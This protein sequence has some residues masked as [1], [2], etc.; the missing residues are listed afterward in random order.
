MRAAR[1]VGSS[2]PFYGRALPL[3]RP[4]SVSR[5]DAARTPKY[6]T[7]L[8]PCGPAPTRTGAGRSTSRPQWHTQGGL[9]GRPAD[10]GRGSA[11]YINYEAELGHRIWISASL[12]LLLRT[13][14]TRTYVRIGTP[15]S[16]SP[17]PV[18]FEIEPKAAQT[19]SRPGQDVM[20]TG[21]ECKYLT[22]AC[23]V[24]GFLAPRA[25]AEADRVSPDFWTFVPSRSS[26]R[27]YV[28]HGRVRLLGHP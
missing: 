13:E 2:V 23:A 24:A 6:T 26:A 11:A 8:R 7:P 27:A 19:A 22:R 14:R 18:D 15:N 25:P 28:R 10:R 5:P 4:Q 20:A 12:S 3:L 9:G 17:L 16:R 21:Y 1:A